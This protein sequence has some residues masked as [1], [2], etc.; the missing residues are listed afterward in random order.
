[1]GQSDQEHILHYTHR[2]L[3]A[4]TDLLNWV[5]L[6]FIFIHYSKFMEITLFEIIPLK[7]G[8]SHFGSHLVPVLSITQ[9]SR[10]VHRFGLAQT[11]LI[12]PL[13]GT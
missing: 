1:M 10:H 2:H 8:C 12:Q 9:P 3:I 7:H 5:S 13:N 4:Y 11:P 6:D